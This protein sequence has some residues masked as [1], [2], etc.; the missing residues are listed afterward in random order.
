M[1]II[2]VLVMGALLGTFYIL[3][4]TGLAIKWLVQKAG[5]HLTKWYKATPSRMSNT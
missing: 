4:F 5:T 2:G 3:V 1:K